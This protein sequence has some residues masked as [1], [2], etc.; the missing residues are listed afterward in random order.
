MFMLCCLI[1][2]NIRKRCLVQK[3]PS[4]QELI[5][6]KTVFLFNRV[7]HSKQAESLNVK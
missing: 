6:K 3:P 2:D 1:T 7:L 4:Q 5:G